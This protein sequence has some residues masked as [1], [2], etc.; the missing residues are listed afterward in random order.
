[1]GASGAYNL[2]LVTDSANVVHELNA[3]ANNTA[4][5]PIQVAISPY[6]D[7]AVSN[8]TA[9]SIAIG[10]PASIN[11]GWTVTNVGTGAGRTTSWKDAIVLS[12][13]DVIGNSDDQVLAEFTH[14]GALAVGASYSDSETVYLPVGASNRYHLFVVSDPE[15][16]VFENGSKANDTAESAQTLDVM[17]SP[18]ADLIVSSVTADPTANSGGS[19]HVSW[20]VANQ[21]IGVTNIQTWD[22]KVALVSSTGVTVAT[23]TFSHLGDVAPNGG[24]SRS[25]DLAVP[26]GISGPF[27][28]AVTTGQDSSLFEFIYANNNSKSSD[29]VNI[30]LSPSPDLVVSDIQVPQLATEGDFIDVSWTVTNTGQAV[31]SGTW[32]DKVVLQPIGQPAA[33][34]IQVG[35]FTHTGDLGIGLSYTRTERFLLPTHIQGVYRASVVTDA[36]FAVYEYGAAAQNDTTVDSDTLSVQVMARP[37]LQVDS[38]VVPTSVPAGGT[39]SMSFTIVNQG[40]VA[41]TTPNW[42]DSVYLSLTNQVTQDAILVGTYDNGAALGPGEKYTTV[43]GPMNIPIRYGGDVYLIVVA[44]SSNQ[45]D[46]YPN[47]GNDSQAFQFHVVPQP[48]ADLVTGNVI[49]PTQVV[50]GAQVSVTFT[51]TNKGSGPTNTDTWNDTVWL[52][53]DK[54]RPGPTDGGILLATVQ[55]TGALNVGDSYNE[56]VNVTIP[57]NIKSG[58]YYLTPWADSYGVVL[59]NELASNINPDDPHEIYNDNY[60]ASQVALIGVDN[61]IF[62]PDLTVTGLVAPAT[63]SAPGAYTVAWTVSNIGAD[64][65]NTSWN[66]DVYLSDQPVLG[67]P[68]ATQW[69]L[70]DFQE[71]GGLAAGQSISFTHTYQ[72][73]PNISAKYLIVAVN[74]PANLDADLANPIPETD[75]QNNIAVASSVVSNNPSDLQVTAINVPQQNFSGDPTTIQYSVTNFG[76]DVWSGSK[77]WT[78]EIFISQAPNFIPPGQPGGA[79]LLGTVV[80]S[81]QAGLLSGQSYTESATVTLPRGIGGDYFIYVITDATTQGPNQE[82][83]SGGTN[84]NANLIGSSFY[85]YTTSVFEQFANT[86]NIGRADIPVTYREPDLQV[87]ALTLPVIAPFSGD[88]ISVSWTVT[89]LGTRQTHENSWSDG[90]FLSSDG[91]LDPGDIELGSVGHLGALAVGQS[92]TVTQQVKLPESIQGNFYII[93]YTDSP[94]STDLSGRN[95]NDITPYP[96]P[97]ISG[98]GSGSVPEFKDEGNNAKAQPLSVTLRTPPDLA[99][100]AI[101]APEQA[102]IGQSLNFSFTVTNVG[103]DTTPLQSSWTDSVYL[104]RDQNLD[105]TSDRYLGSFDHTGGLAAGQS[106][107]VSGT[108]T[109]PTDLNGPYYLIAVT[110][111]S[112]V[113]GKSAVYESNTANN[114]T[115]TSVPILLQQP[116]PADLVVDT[117]TSPLTANVG[118]T[119]TVSW[120]GRN[121]ADNPASGTWTDS[122]YLSSTPEWNYTDPLLGR[123]SYTGTLT[124]NQTYTSTLTAAIPP[125]KL[126]QYYI[127]VRSDI[128]NQVYEGPANSLGELNNFAVAP[129]I[130]SLD[131]PEIQLG[132]PYQTTLS[133]GQSQLLRVTVPQGQTLEVTLTGSSSNESNELFLRYNDAPSGYQYDAIYQSPLQANQTAIIPTTKPGDYYILIRGDQEPTDNTPVTL[134]TV[135]VPLA[136]TNLTQDQGGDSR[137]VTLDIAGAQFDPNAIVK[138]VRPGIAEYEPVNYQVINSTEIQASFD[139]TNAPHGLYDVEVINPNGNVAIDAYRYLIEQAVEPDVTIGLGGPRVILAGDVG[140]YSV[141][142]QS[143]SNVDTPYTYFTYGIPNMGTNFVVYNLPYVT[144]TT[145]LGGQP[146]GANNANIPWASL[147]SATNNNG[148]I[149]APGYLFNMPAGGSTAITFNVDTYPGL[150]QLNDRNWQDFK[151]AMYD[152]GLAAPGSLDAGPQTLDTIAPGLYQAYTEAYAIP[153]QDMYVYIPFRFNIVASAT[154]MTRDEFVAQQTT[155]AETLRQRVL[156]DPTANPALLNLAADAT[157]WQKGY[158]GAL[159]Q[160]GL[161]LPENQA[162]PIQDDAKVQSLMSVLATGV[163]YGPAGSQVTTAGDLLSFFAQIE[164]WY[165]DTPGQLAPIDHYDI[166]QGD[167][168]ELD[169]P[170]PAL[171]QYSTYNL[172]LSDPTY[173]ENFNVYVPWVPF[174]SRGAGGSTVTLPDFGSQAASTTGAALDF[175]QFFQ[176]AASVGDLA[177]ITGPQGYGTQQYLPVGQALPYTIN[178]ANPSTSQTSPGQIQIVTKL[179]PNLDPSTFRLGDLSIGDINVHIPT[180]RAL[181]QGDFDFTQSKGFILRVS[182]GIDTSSDTATWLL[183]AIDPNTGE[184]IQ[185]PNIGLLAPNNAEGAGLGSV[186]YT[187][188]P[189]TGLNTGTTISAQARVLFNTMAPQDTTTLT[190]TLDSTAPTTTLTATNIQGTSD[191]NVQWTAT[192][193]PGGS[194][195]AHVTVYVATDGGNYQIWLRQTTDTSGIY[196]GQAGHT[197]QFLALATDNAG[198]TEQP[199]P[200]VL[201]PSDGS[202]VNLG[203]ALNVGQTTPQD[204][205]P[206]PAPTPSTNPLFITAE[207]GVPAPVPLSNASEFGTVIQPFTAQAFAT[208]IPQSEAGIGPL[209]I[210][211]TPDG[212]ILASGGANR[213]SLYKFG[214]D[215]GV[216]GTP[217]ITLDEPIFNMAFDKDGQLWATTGGGP[218]LLLDAQTGQIKAS[219]GDSITQA[220]AVDPTSGKIYV[221]SGNGIEIFDSVT[222][223]FTHFSNTRVDDLAFS[224]QGEL[225][226]T[227][228]PDRGDVLKFDTKGNAQVMVHLDSEVDSIAF[229]QPGTQ[230]DGILFVSNNSGSAPNGSELIA[231]DTATLQQ[232]AIALNGTRGETLQT[233][234]DGRLLIAQSHQIDVVNP[235]VAPHVAYVNPPDGA[236]APLPLTQ[237]AITFDHDMLAGDGTDPASVLNLANYALTKSTGEAVTITSAQYDVASRTVTLSFDPIDAGSYTL[238]ILH[239]VKSLENVALA[240]DFTSS[241]IAVSDL[242]AQ[243]NVVFDDV[244]SSRADGTVSYDVTVTNTSDNN[245]DAPLTLVLDPGQYFQGQPTTAATQTSDGF[246]LINLGA[247]LAGGILKP[248]QSTTAQTVTVT[249]P[250][251]QHLSIG[252]SVFAV[253]TPTQSPVFDSTPLTTATAGE[254]YQY[255]LAA[256]D[257]NGYSFTYLLMDA[258]E[259]MTLD[260]ST[261]ILSWSPTALSPAQANVV[262]RVYNNFGA[263][264][265]QAFAIDV[266][267]GKQAPVVQDLPAQDTTAEG[268]AY[269][270][271]LSA[272]E[273]DGSALEYFAN[274]LPPGAIFDPKTNQLEWTPGPN[275]AG[276]YQNITLGVTDGVNT[277]T[278]SFTLEVTPVNQPPVLAPVADRTVREGDPIHIQLSAQD[279]ENDPLTYSS[280]LLPPGATLDPTSGVFEWTPSLTEAGVYT[281]PFHV[282]DGTNDTQ[283]NTT[284]TVLD[285]PAA[286]VFDELGP[287]TTLEAQSLSFRA[288]AFDPHNPGFVPQDRL[289]NGQLS[290]L[291]G[292]NPTVTYTVS[293]LP[294]GATFDPVTDMFNWTPTYD[295]SGTYTVH[296]TA[297]ANDDGLPPQISAIDV[298]ITVANVNRPPVVPTLTDQT[299]RLGQVLSLPI[300]VSDPDNDPLN[301]TVLLSRLGTNGVGA[302][303]TT[304]VSLSQ[305]T[306][307]ATLVQN[308]DGSFG[309]RFAPGDGDSGN[310]QITLQAIDNGDGGGPAAALTAQTSFILSVPVADERPVLNAI[311][312]KVAVVG[313]PLSFV[314]QAQDPT[315]DALTFTGDNLPTGMTVTPLAAYG[316]ARIDWTPGTTDV[317]SHPITLHV[318][319]PTNSTS[320]T[321]SLNIVVRSS[322][323]APVL[324]PVGDQTLQEG[325]SFGLQLKAVDP[326]NDPITFSATNL[327]TGSMLDAKSGLFTWTPNYFAAG[328]YAG[329]VFTASDGNKSSSETVTLHVQNVDRPPVFVPMATQT[330][331]ENADMSFTVLAGDSDQD[332]ILFSMQSALPTGATFNRT[333]GVF[334]WTPTYSQGG[335]YTLRFGATDPYGLQS[336][337]DVNV[338]IANTDRAPVLIPSNHQVVLGQQLT[339]SLNGSDPD[340]GDTLT[341]TAKG[342]PDGATLN[343]STGVVQWTPGPGQAGDYLVMATISDGE[344]DTVA[345]VVIRATTSPQLPNVVIVATPSFP[346][347]PGQDVLMHVAATGFADI[348]SLTVTVDGKPVT[349]DA[350]GRFHVTAGQPGKM[351]IVA[352]A[353]DADGLVGT[354]TSVIKVRD[355]NDVVAPVVAFGNQVAG[356]RLTEATDITGQV[357]DTNL[358]SW[359]LE[360]APYGTSAFTTIAQGTSA[361]DQGT[362]VHLDPANYLNGFYTLRLTASDV[363]GRTAQT[364]TQIEIDGQSTTGV[365]SQTVTDMTATLDGHVVAIT[366]QYDSRLSGTP[367]TFG[368]GWRLTLR[369]TDIQSN[370]PLTGQENLGDYDPFEAGTRVYVTLPTG[371]RV[372][373]TFEPVEH[374]IPG[375]VYYTPSF[376]ADP[377][378]TWTLQSAATQLSRVGNRFYD[379]QTGAPYNPAALQ[380]SAQYTLTALDGTAY[381]IDTSLGVTAIRYTDGVKLIV[382]DSGIYAPNGDTVSFVGGTSGIS[383]VIGPNGDQVVYLYDANGNLTLARDLLNGTGSRYG[384]DNAHHLVLTTGGIGSQGV[385]I[386]PA[387]GLATPVTAD[388]G[389]AT[390]YLENAYTGNLASGVTD[391]LTFTVRPSELTSTASGSIY[392][393]FIVNANAGGLTP[394]VPVLSGATLV[395]SQASGNTAFALYKVDQAGLELL[396]IAG[397]TAQAAGAY[398]LEIFVAGDVNHDGTVD[399]TDAALVFAA[400]GTAAGQAGYVA[401]ADANDDGKINATDMQLLFQDLGYRANQAPVATNGTATTHQDLA[402]QLDVSPYI[403]DPEGDPT[404]YRVGGAT[405]GTAVLSSDGKGV[406]FTPTAGFVGQASFSIVAD[407][408]YATSAV[409]TV[410]VTV[411][412]A[413]LIRINLPNI[414]ALTTGDTEQLQITGDFTDA[415]GVVLPIAYVNLTS[416]DPTIV[417]INPDGV[418]KAVASGGAAII[419]TAHGISAARGVLVSDPDPTS[420]GDTPD[421]S[422]VAYPGAFSLVSN[423]GTRQLEISTPDGTDITSSSNGTLYFISNPNVA[424]VSADGF[425]TGVAAGVADITAIYNGSEADIPIRV[426]DPSI[427]PTA[428]GGDGGIVQGTDGSRVA[429]G[430]GVLTSSTTVDIEPLAQAALPLS[431]PSELTAL[432]SFTLSI[433]DS[434]VSVPLQVAVPVASGTPVGTTVYFFRETQ[435]PDA[436][437]NEQPLWLLTET[438]TV[439]ADGLAHTN[440]PPYAGVTKTGTY[441]VAVGQ[442]PGNI[443]STDSQLASAAIVQDPVANYGVMLI[444]GIPLLLPMAFGPQLLVVNTYASG[445]ISSTTTQIVVGPSVSET[446]IH[447]D[448]PAPIGD[449]ETPSITSAQVTF[450]DGTNPQL[451]ITGQQFGTD[452]S[453]VVVR[454]DMGTADPIDVTPTISGNQLTADV[455]KSIFLGLADITVVRKLPADQFDVAGND[456][457]DPIE[458]ES[459]SVTIEPDPNLTFAISPLTSPTPHAVVSVYGSDGQTLLQQIAFPSGDGPGP[460]NSANPIAVTD[461]LTRAYVALGNG[462]IMVIDTVAMREVGEIT[463]V[464]NANL[465]PLPQFSTLVTSGD[466]LFASGLGSA[467]FAFNINPDSD[468]YGEVQ[469]IPIDPAIAPHGVLD[470]AVNADGTKLYATVPETEL[471]AGYFSGERKDGHVVVVNIDPSDEPEDPALGNPDKWM[472]V[473][474]TL[475]AGLQPYR[476]VATGD[477]DR[478]AFTNFLDQYNG[479]ATIQVS[480]EDPNNFQATVKNQL[481]HLDLGTPTQ[482]WDLGIKNARGLAILPDQ[483]YAFVSDWDFENTAD[484][485]HAVEG[486]QIGIIKDPFGP[487]PTYVGATTPISEG[488]ADD[489]ALSPDGK[490]LFADFKGIQQV[491]T[492]DVTAMVD[493]VNTEPAS[494]LSFFPLE[495]LTPTST[496]SGTSLHQDPLVNPDLASTI[497]WGTGISVQSAPIFIN[498]QT[499]YNLGDVNLVDFL[500]PALA[501]ITSSPINSTFKSLVNITPSNFNQ[502]T[503]EVAGYVTTKNEERFLSDSSGTSYYVLPNISD[504]DLSRVRAGKPIGNQ[505]GFVSYDARYLSTLGTEETLHFNIRINFVDKDSQIT[506]KTS[507]LSDKAPAASL[508]DGD[509]QNYYLDYYRIAQ[510]LKYFGYPAWGGTNFNVAKPG[511]TSP[512]GLDASQAEILITAPSDLFTVM[513]VARQGLSATALQNYDPLVI[514][515]LKLFQASVYDV[516]FSGQSNPKASV[517]TPYA[518]SKAATISAL[519]INQP[520]GPYTSDPTTLQWLNSDNAPHWLNLYVAGTQYYVFREGMQ[521]ERYGTTWAFDALNAASKIWSSGVSGQLS[522]TA[523][524]YDSISGQLSSVPSTGKIILTAA[525]NFYSDQ[526][527]P[528]VTQPSND[529]IHHEHKAGMTLDISIPSTLIQNQLS[530]LLTQSISAVSRGNANPNGTSLIRLT[531]ESTRKLVAGSQYGITINTT[532]PGLSGTYSFA[533]I[534]AT[535]IDLLNTIFTS[536]YG[537]GLSTIGVAQA[538]YRDLSL[539]LSPSGTSVSSKIAYYLNQYTDLQE[540]NTFGR[541]RS[542]LQRLTSSEVSVLKEILSFVFALPGEGNAF[543]SALD[544]TALP[545]LVGIYVGKAGTSLDPT[546]QTDYRIR[547][548]LLDIVGNLSNSP[549]GLVVKADDSS[550]FHVVLSTPAINSQ[551]PPSQIAQAALNPSVLNPQS[552][553]PAINVLSTEGQNVWN[554]ASSIWSS[555]SAQVAADLVSLDPVLQTGDLSGSTLGETSLFGKTIMLSPDAAGYGW[556]IDPNPSSSSAFLPTSDPDVFVAPAGSPAY[557]KMDLWTVELHELGHVLGLAEADPTAAP[558][559]LMSQYLAPGVRRLPSAYDLQWLNQV[560][561]SQPSGAAGALQQDAA[562]TLNLQPTNTNIINGNFAVSDNTASNFGWTLLGGATIQSGALALDESSSA[563]TRAY[564]DFIVPTGVT[565]LSFTVTGLN[566][567]ANGNGPPDAFEMALLGNNE[568]SVVGTVNLTN[569]DAAFNVQ[570]DGS[571]F[572]SSKVSVAGASGSLLSGTPVT[573]DVDLSGVAAGTPLRL[574]FDLLGSGPAQSEVKIGNVHLLTAGGD[575]PPVASDVAG[576]VLE[577]G[578]ATTVSASYTD[579]DAGDTHTFS[580][581]LASDHTKGKVTNNG[582][583]SFSYDPNGAFE[584]LAA[585]QTAT[586]KF[587][588]TVTDAAGASSTATVTITITGQNDPPTAANVN[589]TVLEHG[590][591]TTVSASYTDPDAGDTHSF[592]VDL[593]TDHTL[594]KVT[595]NGGGTFSYDPNGAFESLRAGQTGTDQFLYTVTDAAG[596]SSTATVTIT[597]I[598]QNDSPVAANVSGAVLEHGPATTVTASYTDPDA[599]DTHS[600]SVDLSTDHTLG[601][602]TN[603]GNGTFTYDPNGAFASL[604][605]G[606][607]AIDQF[608]YTVTDAAGASSTATVTITITGVGSTNTP[609][610]ASDVTSTV[611]EH[612]PGTTVTASYTDPDAGDTHTFSVDLSTDHTLGKV[613]NNGD[614]T[615]SYDPNGAFE[616]LRAG[617]TATDAFLYTVTDA[618]GASSSATVTITITGQNDPPV[619][620][621]VSGAVLEHGPATTV[622]ASY[623]DPDAGDTHTFSVDLST[624]HT[625]GKVTNNGDGTFSYDPNGAFEALRA[626]QSATDAFLYTVTDAAGASSSATVTITIT[627]QNDPPVAAAVSGAVLEHGPA[628]TVTASY[629]DPDAGDTHTFSIDLSTDHTLGK[630]TNNGDGTFSYDPNGAFEAL[631]AGQT[632]TDKF[633]YTV[634]DAAGA[635]SS[636]TVTITITGQNDPPVAAAVSG[637]VQEHGPATTVSASYTDPDAGDTHTFSVDLSTDHTLGKV[638]NNGD[639]TFSYDP[640]GAFEALRAGQTATDKFLYTVTDAAGASSSATVTITITGQND[641]PVAAAVSGTVQEHGPVTTVSASYADPDAGDTHTFSVDLST[642]HTLGKVTNNGDGTFSYNPNGAFES[643]AAGQS[644]TDKFLYT[645]T[646]A[647]GASSTAMVTITVIGQ[648]D[649]PAITGGLTTATVVEQSGMSGSTSLD[650]VTGTLTFIDVDLADSHTVSVQPHGSNGAGYLGVLSSSIAIDSTR[651]G[652]GSIQWTYQVVDGAL[653]GLA[654][655]QK[656]VQTYDLTVSDGHGGTATQTIAIT[657]VGTDDAPVIAAAD[658]IEIGSPIAETP[659]DEGTFLRQGKIRFTDSDLPDRPTAAVTS[660]TIVAQDQNGRLIN[661]T[662]TQ[663]AAITKGFQLSNEPGNTNYG[664]SDWTYTIADTVVDS[665]T[666][667]N[668]VITLTS[669]V[670]VDDHNGGTDTATVVI[671]LEGTRG[672]PVITSGVTS[673]TVTELPGVTGSTALDQAT[674]ALSFIDAN[675]AAKHTVTVQPNDQCDVGTFQAAIATD[676]TGTGTGAITWTY[677]VSD[678]DL[679]FLAAGQ[680]LVQSYDVVVSDGHGGLSRR[681]ISITL[682]GTE[683]APTAH[684]DIAVVGKSSVLSVGPANGVL[685]NDIDPDVLDTMTVT[686]INGSASQVGRTVTLASGALLKVNA[687]GS[688]SYNPNGKFAALATNQTAIDSFSYTMRDA[689]GL[690]STAT[691]TISIEGSTKAVQASNEIRPVSLTSV[692]GIK[693]LV[694]AVD[695]D[696][697]L[698]TINGVAGGTSLPSGT[699]IQFS[700]VML[701]KHAAEA[702]ITISAPVALP[703]GSVNLADL[704]ISEACPQIDP[705]QITVKSINGTPVQAGSGGAQVTTS[706]MI[707]FGAQ[708]E[709]AALCGS[710]FWFPNAANWKLDFVA[711]LGAVAYGGVNSDLSITLPPEKTSSSTVIN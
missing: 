284:F 389:S 1:L 137:W 152:A 136:I 312:D 461:D 538:D 483:S 170:V 50:A 49:T 601:K 527:A 436:N 339:F 465:P 70:E 322:N 88:T 448:P 330:G 641:P 141:S 224:P 657:L 242:S 139:F 645:V 698:L 181:F 179:D 237:I 600:F 125:T 293:G 597:I 103:G 671:T 539:L 639:G 471:Y 292:T 258:P 376:V 704:L 513:S 222:H 3:K 219:F 38:A 263:S 419:A 360:I 172:N 265:S 616:A 94:F 580:V 229:G 560:L 325:S 308:T 79:T 607:S 306:G 418:V 420:S 48:F 668:Q 504:F 404:F 439:Q 700:T 474:A 320:D 611:E 102:T 665:L 246:W 450:P 214:H 20:S 627:G 412:N 145:N 71:A 468:H 275:S 548:A 524:A 280:P 338:V 557:G 225:W 565:S 29:P 535:H 36:D 505:I 676:S 492:F 194:G 245:I 362:L 368:D 233:T 101:S 247:G 581:D 26:N 540:L 240:Q 460:Y 238:T 695:Y 75:Y 8:V 23:Y 296:F 331:R 63:A 294:N 591:A 603:N 156:A 689:A 497:S 466:Y 223:T 679:D 561:A 392:L 158:L 124:Q 709:S 262:L 32:T 661:L 651:T 687:D 299:V 92:Y 589:D 430:P 562:L 697:T 517:G 42:K 129:N 328:D 295:Q 300:T 60:K 688:Y 309:L 186:S 372:G 529:V 335:Q 200:G 654:A 635:S 543:G 54:T 534:D 9:P 13:D 163:L 286:P 30:A 117:I 598:G 388:L 706:P 467:I 361:F 62:L 12:L 297:T 248:G 393:G 197:Y 586:D 47:D 427:G 133:T 253:P 691:V 506:I 631:R 107:T 183:Q 610:V 66:D 120:V 64:T 135:L 208:G 239:N 100:S 355:P 148:E 173:L 612:G 191:Y 577:Q 588:Y 218:L 707:D 315:Q 552:T 175:S 290:E 115:P 93:V 11:V 383:K 648:N 301:F 371:E 708:F 190:Q 673:A 33:S 606:Q 345:P 201:A 342:L 424:T 7:L 249:N 437:G 710:Q 169:V 568:Q 311:G 375:L 441:L 516:Q 429:V 326:D 143:L 614:G 232:V 431:V 453:Q 440:S 605:A 433:G 542:A 46:E 604:T 690:L 157:T 595:N 378:V 241:F 459:N 390:S 594:G 587:Q 348:A 498:D 56:T 656:L 408:G 637:T 696:P 578:P 212:G 10:N 593:A 462:G 65:G 321:Q 324:L 680:K 386:D 251:G 268:Q 126:G 99:V 407:D 473:I 202:Q 702:L 402:A 113:T 640:N 198:N 336:T 585:G 365:T 349:L 558:N 647:A 494:Q 533:I 370:A 693:T 550:H 216:A 364:E 226:G 455:P 122:V 625:L 4:S 14:N 128:Y 276:T 271:G 366:R 74:P 132:V 228:W 317:G 298:G 302:V 526:Y 210:V 24:Y 283:I 569:T 481:V 525:S 319:D 469:L 347:V 659:N 86:N 176:L 250:F 144:S 236:V 171:A 313:H 234:S 39:V 398:S 304:P 257:P 630:V 140:T 382:S 134:N 316:Q 531:V 602:V 477:P 369:D 25:A 104:S 663:I 43:T 425:V 520:L 618:A 463:S 77:Y 447:V 624:D 391:Q 456:T 220:L 472:Q 189:R 373:F 571:Y 622:S 318:T 518:G 401:G 85:F 341:Y 435:L 686:A 385:S 354:T 359:T 666:L 105:P 344:L 482:F 44:D 278:K 58:V 556:Y 510:R 59:Q 164:K 260:P 417:S 629:T 672:A 289:S 53:L 52:T 332:P 458:F 480:N 620:A 409:A 35:T 243:I 343:A 549:A 511:T 489:I 149:L 184:V 632:A 567:V 277:V 507:T 334:D 195:V 154:P 582:D 613:T 454:Y 374:D 449:A 677:Q 323:Q 399:G 204:V 522:L 329:I 397:S 111:P 264:A 31:A 357:S 146:D 658:K 310:Y 554:Q 131:V 619:A 681:T 206:P 519:P 559:D 590:P 127:I 19:L 151:N 484:T 353:T 5:S 185:N 490:Y 662:S 346:A 356:L 442:G 305:N 18:Y 638:T 650:K 422:L 28:V 684:N 27:T 395:A 255:Q 159:E 209:A 130:L 644:A 675:L 403:S 162:P 78:D 340:T 553:E 596:A 615:F 57:N 177:S 476:I 514:E 470:M 68:G 153:P 112:S 178:F 327:P 502:L 660:Q 400:E 221:S 6:A 87:T 444:S 685:A 678:K 16:A 259:G 17:A 80:H 457:G 537:N 413:A 608:L 623:T 628:T 97:G 165:G 493:V 351:T 495:M 34:P 40:T 192:D 575:T 653:D 51:V 563:S 683:D 405:N 423:G 579:P 486:A 61:P 288:F 488:F 377:G 230:L 547:Q 406:V 394:G 98:S 350:Q 84:G 545:E 267:G 381:D 142:F 415:T 451:V 2:L 572:A 274:H 252:N 203:S 576:T 452:P 150:A 634:T 106:Y 599:G 314:V 109:L 287:Y 261:S 649:P 574:Y 421:T 503:T 682:V 22:D 428:I 244:R 89:N 387:T 333:T 664:A 379:L 254:N 521:P 652:T 655:G 584:N 416:T 182:A 541:T 83:N 235:I 76:G 667:S 272:S 411:S 72:L 508:P 121:Q 694:F 642:D 114:A 108:V 199:P 270:I 384:Y 509:R 573:V 55:H 95:L 81:N 626:G 41:T 701:S 551:T 281:V 119:I 90:I 73:A 15:N 528:T 118:D 711:G 487:N 570:S 291:D 475:Q 213:G 147:K 337:L 555:V 445:A 609:P 438:G 705:I 485:P 138:L 669:V 414:G 500:Q 207:Q 646:D 67:A 256:H 167:Y 37:D 546:A 530:N 496:S 523:K 636:A 434:P 82:F 499:S 303:N 358:D 396:K 592:S 536:A 227:S 699:Q 161:L 123:V 180:G 432:D 583:G 566:F 532:I 211:V 367:G 188:L 279:P 96:G 91:S 446:Q 266:I 380:T 215:G 443:V 21:G 217:L 187:V 544:Q 464:Q 703:A 205:A 564:E 410:T 196:Q 155:E 160:A 426:Q 307:F 633:L 110:N 617:Q 670:K 69:L 282:S 352:T 168:G 269:A 363:A 193:D 285:T 643:L 231:I 621:G 45:V 479:F 515:A 512:K 501:Y 491:E 174:E 116:P 674:G 273:P 166:R 692:G 478:M